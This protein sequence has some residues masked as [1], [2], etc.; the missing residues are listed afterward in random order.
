MEA[1]WE[2][3]WARIAAILVPITVMFWSFV[4]VGQVGEHL[5]CSSPL[6]MRTA[7]SSE[8]LGFMVNFFDFYFYHI[9][10]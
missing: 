9:F 8:A 5:H 3:A 4:S 10:Q 2:A 1:D 6:N 7:G